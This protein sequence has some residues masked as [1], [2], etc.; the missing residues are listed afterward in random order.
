M[1]P[2]RMFPDEGLKAPVKSFDET[3]SGADM[4]AREMDAIILSA[5]L[6]ADGMAVRA[7]GLIYRLPLCHDFGDIHI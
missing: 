4:I 2:P 7:H 5:R 6:V 3:F 1:K